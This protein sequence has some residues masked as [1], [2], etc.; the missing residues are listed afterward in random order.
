MR[1]LIPSQTIAEHNHRKFPVYET[2]VASGT[3]ATIG[4]GLAGVGAVGSLGLGIYNAT[5]GVPGAPNFSQYYKEAQQYVPTPA[6]YAAAQQ[7]QEQ[8][9]LGAGYNPA[10]GFAQQF[11]RAGTQ[12]NIAL[13]NL[14]TPGSQKQRELAQNQLNAYIQGQVPQDVQQQI[15]REVAQ[16]LGGGFNLFSG[17][18]QAPQNFARNLGQT[19]LGLSQYGLSAAPTWQQL[20]NQMV[21]SPVTGAQVGLEAG[22]LGTQQVGQ[23]AQAGLQ[24]QG[25]GMQGAEN[26]YAAQMNQYLA[27]QQQMQGIQ[28]GF[29]ALGSAG[30]SLM[31][32]GILGQ[33]YGGLGSPSTGTGYASTTSPTATGEQTTLMGAGYQSPLQTQISQLPALYSGSP[34]FSSVANPASSFYTNPFGS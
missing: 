15:N 19:S 13:Q 32:A 24:S 25:L 31:S 7:A 1:F 11:A 2:L 21:V 9:L 27:Q 10:E 30:S 34:G 8:N 20:A 33:Y 26:Q 4:L 16:N 12:Q 23:T 14:V 6:E 22:Q 17:G 5:K 3:A 29:G 28:Q 18:G